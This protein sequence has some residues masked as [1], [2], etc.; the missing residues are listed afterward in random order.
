MRLVELVN[1][2]LRQVLYV[3]SCERCGLELYIEAAAAEDD[4]HWKCPECSTW[5]AKEVTNDE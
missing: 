5:N 1:R 2:W 3:V 4:T